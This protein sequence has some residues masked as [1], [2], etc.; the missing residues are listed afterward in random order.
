MFSLWDDASRDAE[1]ENNIR[2]TAMAESELDRGVFSFVALSKTASEYEHRKALVAERLHQ[3]AELTDNTYEDVVR[4]L[5]GK[6]AYILEASRLA[7][8]KGFIL[9]DS[10]EK[11]VGGPFSSRDIAEKAKAKAEP[12]TRIVS[13]SKKNDDDLPDFIKDKKKDKDEG[14]EGS[15][16]DK[17][18]KD[19][20]ESDDED[21]DSKDEKGDKEDDKE[22]NKKESSLSYALRMVRTALDEGVDPIEWVGDLPA[23]SNSGAV[24]SEHNED[25]DPKAGLPGGD[26]PEAP[27]HGLDHSGW[28]A[29]QREANIMDAGKTLMNAGQ[30]AMNSIQNAIPGTGTMPGGPGAAGD[31]G[32]NNPGN[33]PTSPMLSG[34]SPAGGPGATPQMPPGG[35]GEDPSNRAANGMNGMASLRQTIARYNP[36][37]SPRKVDEV[38]RK[39]AVRY[40]RG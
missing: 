13:M 28:M 12:G 14:D 29:D 19:K 23:A 1:A 17:D 4:I 8:N 10:N 3:V 20:D 34:N 33:S 15:D 38:A 16:E 21:D 18:K 35:G 24:P 22:K 26:I 5:D 6:M 37:L 11:K 40:F 32:Q 27:E 25:S 36:H 7:D 2:R 39:V 30:G 31:P 9:I